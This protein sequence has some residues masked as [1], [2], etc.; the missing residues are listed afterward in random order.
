M[1]ENDRKKEVVR[2]LSEIAIYLEEMTEQ[3]QYHHQRQTFRRWG[4][5]VG[6]AIYELRK[7]EK[8][9]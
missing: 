6:D 1:A 3:S 7:D 8:T 2:Q 5:A 9:E 4:V